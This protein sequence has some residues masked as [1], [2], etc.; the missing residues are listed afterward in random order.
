M[1]DADLLVKQ[2]AKGAT[3]VAGTHYSSAGQ[4]ML[5]SGVLRAVRAV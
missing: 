5:C 2:Q 3:A 1:G 4:V